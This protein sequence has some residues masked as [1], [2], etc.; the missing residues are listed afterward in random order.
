MVCVLLQTPSYSV[1]YPHLG[2]F[3]SD[4]VD[5]EA[6]LDVVQKA[7]VLCRLVNLDDICK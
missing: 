5:G 6:A 1:H 3:R 7:E 2:L 4:P